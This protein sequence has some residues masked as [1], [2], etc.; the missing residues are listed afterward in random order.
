VIAYKHYTAKHG[1]PSSLNNH[2][3]FIRHQL[4]AATTQGVYVYNAAHDKFIVSPFYQKIFGQSRVE[5]ITT[6][7]EGNIWFISNQ[8]AGVVD[9]NKKSAS[10]SYTI[11]LFPGA[12]RARP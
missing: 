1:L 5:F 8:R 2:V 11:T 4:I 3:Y 9:F 12:G 7:S 6:D 10:Q